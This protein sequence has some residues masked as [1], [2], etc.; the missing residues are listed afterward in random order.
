MKLSV[1]S[2]EHFMKEAYKQAEMAFEA[3][4][5]PVGAVIVAENR[6][7][8]K[9]HNQTER[10][11]DVTAHAEMLALTSAFNYMG[12]KYLQECTLYVTLEPCVM[13]AGAQFWSQLGKLVYG[14][15][16]S[17]RGFSLH[18]KKI[19]H[20]RTEVTKGLLAVESEALLNQFFSKLR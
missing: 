16:D 10:L 2:D 13:C 1:F 7:I 17:K 18:G 12:G 3:G 8:A 4:E 14:S 6:V 19:I 5:V 15:S 9:A 11:T 20:P